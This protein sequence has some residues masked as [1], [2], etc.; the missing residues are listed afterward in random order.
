MN[1]IFSK[2]ARNQIENWLD[3]NPK[4]VNKIDDLIEDIKE[5]GFLHGKGKPEQLKFYKDP[6]RFS[7]HITSGDRLIYCPCDGNDLLIISCKGHYGDK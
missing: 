1:V 7:R 4:T 3:S 6:P 5:N 2:T